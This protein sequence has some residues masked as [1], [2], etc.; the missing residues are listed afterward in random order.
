MK[1]SYFIENIKCDGC[2]NSICSAAMSITGI[3][4]VEVNIDNQSVTIESDQVEAIEKVLE[5]LNQLGYPALGNNNV[6]KKAKSYVSCAIG[7]MDVA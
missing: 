7:R 6:L 3:D 5:K 1:E 2:A 4:F